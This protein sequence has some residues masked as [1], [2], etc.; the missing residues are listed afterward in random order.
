MAK[1]EIKKQKQ[2][3]VNNSGQIGQFGSA[4]AGTKVTSI[5]PDVLQNLSAFEDGWSA[6]TLSLIHI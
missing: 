2:F 1:I 6:A 5:D 4:Q 3:A